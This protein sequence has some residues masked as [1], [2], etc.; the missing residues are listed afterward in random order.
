M[1]IYFAASIRAGRGD[2][3]I[4]YSLVSYLKNHGKVLTEHV[5]D[6]S[7][8]EGGEIH[9]SDED[10][11]KRDMDWRRESDVFVAEVST[12]SLGVGY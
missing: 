10:I 6:V 2:V 5:G 12:P 9:L 3:D 1:K 8:H 4:Y 11:Y 7:L